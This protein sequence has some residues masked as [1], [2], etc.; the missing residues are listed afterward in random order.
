MSKN[1]FANYQLPQQGIQITSLE[2]HTAGE[3]L[4]IITSGFPHLEGETIL[5]KRNYCQQNYDHLRKAIIFEP[6]G[7][8]DM[9]AAVITEPERKDSHFGVLFLHNEGYSTMCGHA[10]IALSRAAI[11][12]GVV[13]KQE[14][15]TEIRI[16][17]PA[18]LIVSYVTIK[19]GQ[20]QNIRFNNVP[21]YLALEDQAVVVKG[22]GEVKFDLAF[23]GAFY[24][25][26]NADDLKLSLTSDNSTQLRQIATQIKQSVQQQFEIKHPFEG[27][28]SFLYGVIFVSHKQVKSKTSHSRNVCIFA[29]AELDRSP[30]GTGV[31]A[32]AAIHFSKGEIALNQAIQIE[33]IL[34]TSFTVK[35]VEECT[36]G[37]YPAVI[38]EVS[39]MAY[40]TGINT[41]YIDPADP[42][43][44]GF[45]LK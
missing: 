44:E 19:N 33:S 24:A 37:E 10:I 36:F 4:R 9:Y 34:G 32:R 35:A 29:D 23:G 26:V 12:S 21:S 5:Q 28:L 8:T 17:S 41:F 45:I 31:S 27:D 40:V 13:E 18:G 30:T 38:P 43:C 22:L 25:Y 6:R 3:P 1:L 2:M 42:F 16:D 15:E 7:H 20:V 11:E 14:P 39:G